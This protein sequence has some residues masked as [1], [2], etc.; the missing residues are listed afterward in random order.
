MLF[1]LILGVLIIRFFI[2]GKYLLI[3]KS[4][5]LN[6]CYTFTK[7][8]IYLNKHRKTFYIPYYDTYKDGSVTPYNILKYFGETSASHTDQ[9]TSKKEETSKS[10]YGWMLYRWKVKIDKY[11]KAK[12]KIHIDTWASKVDRFY[13][14][15]EFTILNEDEEILGI[16]STVWIFVDMEKKRPIRI[17]DKFIENIDIISESNF[18]EFEDFKGKIETDS[19]IEFMVRR[20]DIDY[21]NHVNNAKYLS[22]IL[23]SIPDDIFENYMLYEFEIIY[24]R[25]IKYGDIILS[26]NKEDE[27]K[28][29]EV[30]FIHKISVGKSQKDHAYGLTKWKKMS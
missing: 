8:L 12:E 2:Y 7:E 30:S 13:A 3:I 23:E 6:Q 11:P 4:D 27:V 21:N 9:S 1:L 16:A 25:E 14:Y 10:N 29:K 15:R 20:S 22:W 19:Y 24:K 18:N 5:I 26:K 28:N 17:P